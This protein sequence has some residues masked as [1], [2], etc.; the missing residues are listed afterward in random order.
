MKV[1]GLIAI[2][3]GVLILAVGV[4]GVV[5]LVRTIPWSLL[6]CGLIAILCGVICK[7]LDRVH[8][9]LLALESKL[10]KIEDATRSYATGQIADQL[11]QEGLLRSETTAA[12]QSV[13]ETA[14]H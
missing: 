3:A 10:S 13:D 6:L 8:V 1:L 5:L 14:D 2:I 4:V 12:D 7:H 11:R 9:R